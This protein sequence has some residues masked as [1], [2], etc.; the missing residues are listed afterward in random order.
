MEDFV[1]I[2]LEHEFAI[3]KWGAIHME[4]DYI[5]LINDILKDIKDEKILKKIYTFIKYFVS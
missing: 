4:V 5:K 2:E 1:I 3:W